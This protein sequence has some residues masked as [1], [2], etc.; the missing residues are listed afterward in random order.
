MNYF[1][2]DI[3]TCPL[4]LEN[5]GE[6]SEDEKL[7]RINPIDSEIVALGI[8]YKGKNTIFLEENEKK[9]LDGFWSEWKRIKADS[10]APVVGFNINNFDLPFITTRSLIKKVVISPFIL[11]ET[12]DLREKI[13]AYQ[14]HPRGKLKEYATLLGLPFLEGMDG[15]QVADL[16][17]Q[18][19]FKKIAEYLISDLEVTDELYKRVRDTNI[20]GISRW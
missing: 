18:R 9:M 2:M 1:V 5:Y 15:S 11:K 3:E 10:N 16:Y 19:D 20:L 6:L 4:D 14:Y 8:R 7:K 17:M 12:I 13:S